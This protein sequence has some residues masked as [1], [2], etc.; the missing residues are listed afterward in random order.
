MDKVEESDVKKDNFIE[1]R[2]EQIS[3]NADNADIDFSNL[4]EDLNYYRNHPINLNKATPEELQALTLLTDIQIV[5]LLKHIKNTGKLIAIYELQ[6]VDGFTLAD[7][8]K[9][10]PF[11]YVDDTFNEPV[12]TFKNLLKNG[13]HMFVTRVQLVGEKQKGYEDVSDSVLAIKPNA[14]YL[15][16]PIGTF[17]RYRYQFGNKISIGI[18]ADKDPGEEFFKGTQKQG[19]DFYSA[20]AYIS[21]FKFIKSFAIGDYQLQLGQGLT[22]WMGL[23]YGKTADPMLIKRNARGLRPNN[24]LNENLFMR[25]VA[26]TIKAGNFFVTGFYSANKVDAS[27]NSDTLD[28]VVE[29]IATLQLSGLH[30]TPSEVES[31]NFLTQYIR[32]GNIN[33]KK[34]LLSVGFTA[35]QTAFSKTVDRDLSI[36][37]QYDFQGASLVNLGADYNFV[38]RNFNFFGEVSRSSNNAY[39]QIH[40]AIITLDPRLYIT[41]SYRN[42]SLLYQ[43]F[44]SNAVGENTRNNN[45]KGFMFGMVAKPVKMISLAG[46]Y[47]R[48]TFP[49][50]RYQVNAPSRGNDFLLQLN[51]TPN[52]KTDIY[53]RVRKRIKEKSNSSSTEAIDEMVGTFQTNYRFN[54][55]YSVSKSVRLRSRIDVVEYK[56]GDKTS[57]GFMIFQDVNYNPNMSKLSF[58]LRYGI[59]N[60]DDYYSRIY[61]YENNVPYAYLIPSFYNKGTRAY[62]TIDY[63]V[64]K[65]L[66]FW[67]R[68]ANTWYANVDKISE[69]SLSEIDNNHRTDLTLQMRYKFH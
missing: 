4:L 13:T 28:N 59:F 24:S 64:N 47:D 27:V 23:G 48:F 51:Y 19:Y 10:L 35:V 21:D 46:Y 9:I 18:T 43:N 60:A 37:N 40:G 45:E 34:R 3:E 69:G 7:I 56:I 26:T 25:G 62:I 42:Y 32:G 31:K 36:Y 66:E 5:N 16:S 22:F 67:F 2:V 15:G 52:K 11:V 65:H 29:S 1:Q 63:S 41:A 58:S 30:R 53:L 68:V 44:N 20:H 33:Y 6:S 12:Y 17:A 61:T 55:I 38:L 57:K 49:Y 50:L 54:V 39:A 14:K 8:N